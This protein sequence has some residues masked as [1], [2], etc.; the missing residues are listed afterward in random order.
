MLDSKTSVGV[1]N[2]II[3]FSKPDSIRRTSTDHNYQAIKGLLIEL[4]FSLWLGHKEQNRRRRGRQRGTMGVGCK[5]KGRR[6]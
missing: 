4:I 1:S 5:S 6:S 2:D 3:S